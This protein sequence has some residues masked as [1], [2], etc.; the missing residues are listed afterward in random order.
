MTPIASS[1]ARI[2]TPSQDLACVPMPRVPIC[3]N[4]SSELSTSGSRRL[5]DA[6]REAFAELERLLRLA[7]AGLAV[8]RELDHLR[9]LVEQGDVHDVRV[10]HAAHLLA[11]EL[12]Q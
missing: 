1:P 7:A 3:S 5:E 12:D 2:G 8:V 10:E 4:C 9:R 6:R 11:D